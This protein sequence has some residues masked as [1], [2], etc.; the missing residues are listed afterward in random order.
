[1][2]ENKIMAVEI[3]DSILDKTFGLRL[4]EAIVETYEKP[5]V[6][7]RIE[8][9]VMTPSVRSQASNVKMKQP[10]KRE[11]M[12]GVERRSIDSIKTS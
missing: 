2:G 8:K 10:V 4:F 11:V 6:K 3:I 7:A 5:I 12:E 9:K 1:M